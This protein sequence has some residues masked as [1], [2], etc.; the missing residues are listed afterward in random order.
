SP[1]DG[2]PPAAMSIRSEAPVHDLRFEDLNFSYRPAWPFGGSPTRVFA[3][4]TWAVSSVPTVLLGPNG[5]GKT[6]LLCLAA[7]ALKPESGHVFVGSRDCSKRRDLG[8]IRRSI[9]WMPQ[10]V[11]AVPGFTSR[12]QVAYA[13]WLA[14]MSR[15]EAW[16]EAIPALERVSLADDSNRLTS[17]L[18]GG[19]QR[20]VGLAQALVHR[21]AMLLLDEPTAGLDPAQRAKFRE[22]V[23][24]V[25]K[26][27]AILV[28][29]HQV[30]DLSDLFK[31]VAVLDAGRIVF[32][33]A[34]DAFLELAP[35]GSQHPAE[36]AY[37]RLVVG[38]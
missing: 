11:R 10:Q 33:G 4:F 32:E 20:R 7:T 28:S 14:G 16:R 34:P 23:R 6:T 2:R 22:I 12:E 17:Q 29:T 15:S 21:P 25:S 35:S 27:S 19:Q 30:D 18:S 24:D 9:G 3:Q 13:G 26:E 31:T 38:K 1:T 8:A 37:T 5:A 36:D